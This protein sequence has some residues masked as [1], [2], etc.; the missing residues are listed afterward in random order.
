M[1]LKHR[2]WALQIFRRQRDALS[3]HTSD[4]GCAKGVEMKIEPISQDPHI[5]KYTPLAHAVREQVRA[6]LDQMLE[7][8]IIQECDEPSPFCSNLLVVKKKDGKSIRIL[9]DGRLL[10]N[11][12]R[13]LPTNLVT[14]LELYAHLANAKWVTTIDLSE[15][16][17]QI[18]LE[19]LLQKYTVFY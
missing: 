12:T 1:P 8:G 2:T 10:N 5:Q 7:F 17:F 4:L 15:A 18:P 6:I 16:F 13:R 11:Q 19:K 9:L 3:K 14:H